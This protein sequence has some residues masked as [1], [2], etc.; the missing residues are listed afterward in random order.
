MLKGSPHAQVHITVY[1]ETMPF[2]ALYK[3]VPTDKLGHIFGGDGN[4]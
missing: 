3:A 4:D 2:E 1:S